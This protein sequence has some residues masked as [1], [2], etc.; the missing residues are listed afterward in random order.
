MQ[1]CGR[2]DVTDPHI[3]AVIKIHVCRVGPDIHIRPECEAQSRAARSRLP[4][5]APSVDESTSGYQLTHRNRRPTDTILQAVK[6]K[7]RI[8]RLDRSEEHTSEL[9][10]RF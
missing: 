3:P 10:S 5:E 2:R 9:Q 4:D 8:D 7:S 1:T 6:P